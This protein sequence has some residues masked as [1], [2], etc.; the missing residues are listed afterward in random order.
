VAAG[1][2]GCISRVG[3]E[4]PP[5]LAALGQFPH[6]HFSPFLRQSAKNLPP[7]FLVT[8]RNFLWPLQNLLPSL[9]S[10]L[11]HGLPRNSLFLEND[12]LRDWLPFRRQRCWRLLRPRRLSKTSRSFQLF[13]PPLPPQSLPFSAP[14]PRFADRPNSFLKET[15]SFGPT[16][17]Q[18]GPGLNVRVF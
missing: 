4:D 13:R 11:F 14:T 18:P 2:K 15:V 10:V 3:F 5:F 7:D 9:S 17:F 6:K 8:A 1:G 12:F 16:S